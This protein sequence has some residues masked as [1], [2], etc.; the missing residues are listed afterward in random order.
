MTDKEKLKDKM[1]EYIDSVLALAE[2]QGTL[3]Y[4]KVE[5]KNNKGQL[6]V[7]STVQNRAKVY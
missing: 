6:H 7:E 4:F 3:D 2:N 1:I 5:F